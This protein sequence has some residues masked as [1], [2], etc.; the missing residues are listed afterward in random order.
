MRSYAVFLS[1]QA[2]PPCRCFFHSMDSFDT[3]SS[4]DKFVLASTALRNLKDC[5]DMH[6]SYSDHVLT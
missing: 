6:C 2:L 3:L 5:L 1:C 4:A